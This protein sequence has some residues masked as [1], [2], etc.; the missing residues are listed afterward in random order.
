[1][2]NDFEIEQIKIKNMEVQPLPTGGKLEH[3]FT[4]NL[5]EEDMLETL[6]FLHIQ[7]I[8]IKMLKKTCWRIWL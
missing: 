1:M 3:L 5:I 6:L 4:K 7:M 2:F 8:E